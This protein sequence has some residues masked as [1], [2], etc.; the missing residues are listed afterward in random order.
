M[1]KKTKEAVKTTAAIVI[2]VVVALVIWVY[3]LYESGKIVARPESEPAMPDIE[4]LGLAADTLSFLTEDNLRLRGMLFSAAN[5]PGGSASG[6]S[7]KGTV[8]LLHGL[9]EGMSSQLEKASALVNA[10]FRVIAYDQRGY[11]LSEGRF[12]SGGYFE[13]NDL[14]EAVARLYLENRLAHP[15][16]VWGEDH[17]AAAALRA[18]QENTAIDYVVSE[19][20]VM[21]GRDWQK[22][23]VHHDSLSAPDIMLGIIWWWMK[24]KSGYEIQHQET[25]LNDYI[26]TAVVK[27][28]D[29]LLVVACGNNNIPDNSYIADIAG[30]GGNW[31]ILPC[32]GNTLFAGHKDAILSAIM[33][34]IKQP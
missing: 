21:I 17:G 30:I 26:G 5:K 10:G 23:V 34:M 18:W 12:R 33:A 14:Q 11:G 7:A 32:A 16:I 29:R 8:I 20:P 27:R 19:N 4:T 22:R 28:P 9:F 2:A 31:L 24:Q 13:G 1:T 15:V 25:D 3:P 6:D